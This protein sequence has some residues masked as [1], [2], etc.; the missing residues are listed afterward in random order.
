[1][2]TLRFDLKDGTT[3]VRNFEKDIADKMLKNAE[4]GYIFCCRI[5]CDDCSMKDKECTWTPTKGRVLFNTSVKV[6]EVPRLSHTQ[7]ADRLLR[8][9]KPCAE[10]Y[11]KDVEIQMLEDELEDIKGYKMNK[12]DINENQLP[13]GDFICVLQAS[14]NYKPKQNPTKRTD[15]SYE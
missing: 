2:K 3:L 6:S 9:N 7:Q 15:K 1:M 4:Y 8:P 10:C 5:S 14:F 11:K 13:L 12:V